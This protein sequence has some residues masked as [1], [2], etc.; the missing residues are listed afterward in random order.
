MALFEKDG[1]LT[2]KGNHYQVGELLEMLPYVKG[3]N[4]ANFL[5]SIGLNIPRK[6]RMGVLKNV[7]KTSVEKTIEERK[8]LADE[9]GY[10]LTW[11]AKYTDTQLVNLLEW[12]KSPSLSQVYL[13][14][15]WNVLL[16][17]LVEKGVAEGDL[18]TLFTLAEA[19]F[20]KKEKVLSKE[21]NDALNKVLFDV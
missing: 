11:F 14:E 18:E 17:Y 13:Q 15:L 9:M 12:Y 6:M 21:F 20:K 19:A 8:S 2:V 4:L 5:Q 7:L 3:E 16:P 1:H 10:R